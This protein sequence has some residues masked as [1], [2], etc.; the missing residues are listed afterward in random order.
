MTDK[1][2]SFEHLS[3]VLSE[4]SDDEING[5]LALV[6]R[7]RAGMPV[8]DDMPHLQSTIGHLDPDAL[9][10]LDAVLCVRLQ[11]ADREVAWRRFAE[12]AYRELVPPSR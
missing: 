8:K 4:I 5:A 10:W 1:G 2:Q 6:R 7:H 11:Q 3:R 9:S 12:A